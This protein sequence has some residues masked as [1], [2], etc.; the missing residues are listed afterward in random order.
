MKR[1]T[2]LFFTTL[3][4]CS[5]SMAEP[6]DI[7]L[8]ATKNATGL[9]ERLITLESSRSPQFF[10]KLSPKQTPPPGTIF[11][12]ITVC[13]IEQ[14]HH[15]ALAYSEG[16]AALKQPVVSFRFSPLPEYI[17]KEN[18][19][20]VIMQYIPLNDDHT[21]VARYQLSCAYQPI[22]APPA[23]QERHNHL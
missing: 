2:L 9:G 18:S 17:G 13:A 19:F 1:I 12:D 11:L 22:S 3:L 21:A 14:L 4:N 5:I 6:I 10:C 8:N 16:H 7:S 23:P 15:C 20:A